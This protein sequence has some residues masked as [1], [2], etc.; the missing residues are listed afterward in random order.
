MYIV[1]GQGHVFGA[2]LYLEIDLDSRAEALADSWLTGHGV[3]A[4]C[5]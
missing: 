1:Q 5:R 2:A 4:R 3:I